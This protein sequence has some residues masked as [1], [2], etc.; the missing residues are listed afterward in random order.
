M[1]L[2]ANLQASFARTLRKYNAE[3]Y[4]L[5][6]SGGCDSMVLLSLFQEQDKHFTVLHVNYN[7]RG[8]ESDKDETL[9]R[10]YCKIKSI[11]IY[12]LNYD[13][14]ADLKDGGNMQS[15]ARKIRYDFFKT[16]LSKHKTSMLCLGH[17]KDDQEESFWLSM[18]RGGGLRAMAGMNTFNTPF[19]RP[20]LNY[21]KEELVSYAL[22]QKIIWREDQSNQSNKYARNIWRNILLPQ[23]KV[24]IPDISESVEILQRHFKQQVKYDRKLSRSYIPY[25][26][27]D[28][29]IRASD[30]SCMN[31]NQWIE[32]L[33]QMNI[34]KN[35][36]FPLLNLMGSENGKKI[37]LN[38]ED[39]N[40]QTVWKREN[41][42]YFEL[43]DQPPSLPPFFYSYIVDSFPKEFSKTELYLNPKK[44]KGIL[45]IR[46]WENGDRML[47]VGLKGSKLISDILKD[48]KAVA[49]NKSKHWVL[50]D[51]EKIIS[52][53]GYR[54]DQRSIADGAPC[55]KVVI[56]L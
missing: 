30:L 31:S 6:V 51:E 45:S 53:L 44:L 20:F 39:S 19:L 36:A 47:P 35:L 11:P 26:A 52:L 24:K 8:E 25:P 14:S 50:V 54:I 16:F 2:V 9:L 33:D 37:I 43:K 7:L 10:D 32:F 56:E 29:E 22:A 46:K 21:T 34:G 3:H 40:Y 55:L 15:T 27:Q 49:S 41:G 5:A 1:E 13:L 12:V 28:F 17:H 42:L 23:L 18:A 4:Y 38:S 48:D